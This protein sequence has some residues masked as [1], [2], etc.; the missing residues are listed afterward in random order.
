MLSCY[1]SQTICNEIFKISSVMFQYRC[2][3][4][5]TIFS[6]ALISINYSK[7]LD[8]IGFIQYFHKVVVEK[9]N[10][11]ISTCLPKLPF[12]EPFSSAF[13]YFGIFLCPSR[14]YHLLGRRVL[15]VKVRNPVVFG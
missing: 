4:V 14:A 8:W 1:E 11:V 5:P 2:L 10:F 15:A 9:I 12:I 3:K 7:P 6:K 13:V